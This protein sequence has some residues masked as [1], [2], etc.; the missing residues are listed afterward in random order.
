MRP[1]ERIYGG[2]GVRAGRHHLTQ[3]AL[4]GGEQI[5]VTVEFLP[6]GIPRGA[7][8]ARGMAQP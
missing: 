2:Q 6:T 5:A 8:A 4:P 7:A 1:I 3:V